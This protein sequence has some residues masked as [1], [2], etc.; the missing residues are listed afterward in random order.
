MI[1]RK[2][3]LWLA[4]VILFSICIAPGM[5]AYCS[6]ELAVSAIECKF[7]GNIVADQLD[8]IPYM[9]DSISLTFN[10]DLDE[11]S[12]AGN[13]TLISESDRVNM[14][15]DSSI[16]EDKK[17]LQI[18]IKE[19]MRKNSGYNLKIGENIRGADGSVPVG[20]IA[21]SFMTDDKETTIIFDEYF[22]EDFDGYVP[23]A[24][25][26][27]FPSG[28]YRANNAGAAIGLDGMFRSEGT[29]GY[30]G[31]GALQMASG[32]QNQRV[33]KKFDK[34]VPYGMPVSVDFDVYRAGGC[35]FYVCMLAEDLDFGG[36]VTLPDGTTHSNYA[37]LTVGTAPSYLDPNISSVAPKFGY[38]PYYTDWKLYEF[39]DNSDSNLLL[40]P[41]GWHSVHMELNPVGEAQTIISVSIDGGKVFK[42]TTMQDFYTH[43]MAGIALFGLRVL[44]GNRLV[45]PMDVRF[46]NIHVYAV[47]TA[48]NPEVISA[49]AINADGRKSDMNEPIPSDAVS[50]EVIFNSAVDSINNIGDF[51]ELTC[52]GNIIPCTA[53]IFDLGR[54]IRVI[55]QNLLAANESYKLTLKKG[56]PSKY[57]KLLTSEQDQ[58][59]Y[60]RTRDDGKFQF[61][62]A[63]IEIAENSAIFTANFLKTADTADKYVMFAAEYATEA[64]TINGKLKKTDRMVG[65]ETKIIAFDKN[66]YGDVAKNIEI[67]KRGNGK[68]FAGYILK[69]DGKYVSSA[70]KYSGGMVTSDAKNVFAGSDSVVTADKNALALPYGYTA[71]GSS[72]CVLVFKGDMDK[73]NFE[74]TSIKD[75]LA[76]IGM[77]QNNGADMVSFFTL[78]EP[79]K[80]TAF[81]L[82]DDDSEIVR[83]P[84]SYVNKTENK[85]ALNAVK[86]AV[87]NQSGSDNFLNIIDSNID[88]IAYNAEYYKQN[89][90]AAAA[91]I[92]NHLVKT[93]GT[94]ASVI[95]NE[96]LSDVLNK[97]YFISALKSDS[98]SDIGNAIYENV[99]GN[100]Y[101]KYYLRGNSS[102]NTFI[103]NA[104]KAAETIYAYETILKETVCLSS[105]AYSGDPQTVKAVTQY[106]GL[107][108]LPD[109]VIRSIN[110]QVFRSVED[111]K[112]K[113]N[114][115]NGN[116]SG[117]GSGSGAG[118][119]SSGGSFVSK[120]TKSADQKLSGI[121][122][123]NTSEKNT[124]ENVDTQIFNDIAGVNWA[125]EAIESLYYKGI[126]SGRGDNQFAPSDNVLR[127]E[128]AKMI[129]DAFRLNTIGDNMNFGDVDP[130]QWYFKYIASAYYSGIISGQSENLFGTGKNITRQDLAVMIYNACK[131]CDIELPDTGK[132]VS[133]GDEALISGY[134]LDAVSALCK[135]GIISGYDGEFHP[136]DNA[137]RAEAAKILY[138]IL[139][140]VK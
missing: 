64:K 112:K 7:A 25:G 116:G 24:A 136:L 132:S 123:P 11:E 50:F 140:Y 35:G 96:I 40:E 43:K 127:E 75:K 105:I 20:E 13:V 1:K 28:W 8:V 34:T 76:Y 26:T 93:Y 69:L 101:E 77:M 129:V 110:G 36:S 115:L 134:A 119:G 14:D 71:D 82:K 90:A 23:N 49:S 84:F 106:L 2:I 3:A 70:E 42:A 31:D 98:I 18:S 15:I 100:D 131:V 125:K 33:M 10:T 120:N 60:F 9:T 57:S 68:K 126:V 63:D 124:N 118:S 39:K 48:Q 66:D 138:N 30:D 89:D 83:I 54:G 29:K 46:D 86:E 109:N 113:I 53:E 88:G 59:V 37:N 79:G 114:E 55:P 130:S 122:Y 58:S 32:T 5:T 22:K 128:F 51:I 87:T 94:D 107:G 73:I 44:D 38:A 45:E 104:L 47:D 16:A 135:A 52:G 95:T 80:Y 117:S 12:I 6:G 56:L 41:D 103:K 65:A 17:T 61:L 108:D 21:F 4:M 102:A 62:S 74:D 19:A 67:G 97:A 81:V 85:T 78:G 27:A 133:F 91:M 139:Q 92:Y 137:T 121:T 99:Y 111:L 72:A